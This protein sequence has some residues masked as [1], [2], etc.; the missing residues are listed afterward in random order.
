M[1][2]PD[3]PLESDAGYP[4]PAVAWYAVIVLLLCYTLS[5]IDRTIISLLV[6]PIKADFGLSDSQFGL[7]TGIAFA[8]MYTGVGLPMGW[9]VDRSRRCMVITAGVVTWSA[10][11]IGC[12]LAKSYGALFGS[13]MMVG[14][15][16]A[17]L[18]PAADS[19][20]ADLFPL[21]KRAAGFATYH[22]GVSL[23]SGLALVIGGTVI[24]FVGTG[25]LVEFPIVGALKAWQAAFVVVGFAGFFIAALTLTVPEPI[26]HGLMKGRKTFSL[27]EGFSFLHGR[28]SLYVA[29]IVGVALMSSTNSGFTAWMPAMMMRNYGWQQHEV[30]QAY[31]MVALTFGVL[32]AASTMAF[33]DTLLKRYNTRVM[34]TLY[35]CA[36]VFQ[37]S[38]ML[39][40]SPYATLALMAV[41]AFALGATPALSTALMQQIT[42]N[43]IRGQV[44]ALHLF[45]SAIIGAG[46][47]PVVPALLSDFVF[48]E[49]GGV[50]YSL[51]CVAAILP[52][53]GAL[54]MLLGSRRA[55]AAVAEAA[56][57]GI[58]STQERS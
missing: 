46:V 52:A 26:R 27:R 6:T 5:Y 42:P 18:T 53:C 35:L 43:Q 23:G 3:Q 48:T 7:L 9:L 17:T 29:L 51:A 49:P 2:T 1:N 37:V 21:R 10:A 30:G 4:R 28:A 13:R 57:W 45:T 54:L 38:A 11:T 22:L 33:G 56:T 19:I 50:R 20:I 39:V 34:A 14:V 16:E 31:G 41:P 36:A 47:G 25:N 55:P 44:V 58:A 8:L 12:G 15:G 40:N 24:Q 32:G